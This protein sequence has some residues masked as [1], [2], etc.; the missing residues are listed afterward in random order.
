MSHYNAPHYNSVSRRTRALNFLLAG[1]LVLLPNGS[2]ADDSFRVVT[3]IKPVHSILASLMT[4]TIA[5]QLLLDG[6]DVPFDYQLNENQQSAING[7]DLIVWVGPELETFMVEPVQ[8]ATRSGK[9]VL[10]LLD[11]SEIKVLPSRWSDNEAT[12]KRDPYFWMDSRNMLI[13]VDELAKSLMD[14]DNARSHLYRRNREDLLYKIAELDRKLEFGYRGL[15]SGLGMTYF[16][17]LQYFEQA[18]ALKIREVLAESPDKPLDAASLLERRAELKEGV[19]ACLITDQGLAMKELPLLT[20]D[21]SINTGIIDTFGTQYDAG[22]DLY[23]NMMQDSTDAIKNCLRYGDQPHLLANSEDTA[24]I[25]ALPG[26][27]FM[28]MDHN[29]KLTTETDML[30]K[31]QLINFGYTHCP[32]VCPNTLQVMTSALKKLGDRANLIN[33]YFISIDP[34]RDDVESINSY[35]GFF[36]DNLTGLTGTSTMIQRMAKQYKVLYEKV[37]SDSGDPEY[38]TMD[39]TASLY[40]MAPDGEFITKFAY[41]ISPQQLLDG[42]N[43]Y[44]PN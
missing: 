3:T 25:N 4:G 33:P 12:A 1:F 17:T 15:K 21:L 28:L 32:D 7:A 19:Y 6:T 11:N 13:L 39:H 41:G 31:Y 5:P 37:E 14:A 40:L 22:P 43:D 30:G 34:E 44:L 20:N 26:G 38:Y 24:P 8:S 18:Y 2:N 10:T 42:L 23:F 16:D 29:G 27:K 35:V 9:N 36:S